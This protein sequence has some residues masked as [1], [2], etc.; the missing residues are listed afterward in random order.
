M[1]NNFITDVAEQIFGDLFCKENENLS[2]DELIFLIKKRLI[3]FGEDSRQL[4][5]RQILNHFL[6]EIKEIQSLAEISV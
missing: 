3:P 5:K 4:G 6:K 1:N 2:K